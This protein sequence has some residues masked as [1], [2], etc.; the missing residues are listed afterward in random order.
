MVA[1]GSFDG[2][3]LLKPKPELPPD[4]FDEP[5]T[6]L[7]RTV[8]DAISEVV[9]LFGDNISH[10]TRIH[11]RTGRKE[12]LILLPTA[13]VPDR[14]TL[15]KFIQDPKT[16]LLTQDISEDYFNELWRRYFWF[17]G[18]R[19]WLPFAK[20][21]TCT[22]L[23]LKIFTA[24][25]R[26]DR[27]DGRQQQ[28]EHR[29]QVQ[30]CRKRVDDRLGLKLDSNREGFL[31]IAIDAMDSNKTDLPRYRSDALL[32]KDLESEGKPLGCRL[33]GADVEHIGFFGFWTLPMYAQGGNLV[34]TVLLRLLKLIPLKTGRVLP[35]ILLLQLDNTVKENK[36][37]AVYGFLSLLIQVIMV[38]ATSHKICN[39]PP[40]ANC[41]A[42]AIYHMNDLSVPCIVTGGRFQRDPCAFPAGRTHACQD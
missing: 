10:E 9:H 7:Q 19:D 8:F 38:Y 33:I 2:V 3:R 13:I 14:K 25:N 37:N 35:P 27:L 23:R 6:P 29:E 16:G 21:D 5:T 22:G 15:L 40:N 12:S 4:R 28:K 17:V 32:C 24:K 41:V 26:Q 1:A 30:Q 36:N 42:H 20:C 31:R 18:I 11:P 34:P 39:E